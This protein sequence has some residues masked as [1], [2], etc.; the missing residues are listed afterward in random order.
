[1][2]G[3][4]MMRVAKL[5]YLDRKTTGARAGGKN[6]TQKKATKLTVC[7]CIMCVETKESRFVPFWKMQKT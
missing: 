5:G 7:F 3:L 2:L 4:D 1:M 6:T